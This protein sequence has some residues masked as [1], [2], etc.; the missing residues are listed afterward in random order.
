PGIRNI[1]WIVEVG[2]KQR[3]DGRLAV[4]SGASASGSA[5]RI[6]AGPEIAKGILIHALDPRFTFEDFIVA[7]SNELAYAASY[8][9]ADS[10]TVPFNPA[11]LYGGIAL[12]STPRMPATA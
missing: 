1:E 11:C 2:V 10:P 3:D 6:E 8:R 9:V 7:K 12:R 5:G 4:N